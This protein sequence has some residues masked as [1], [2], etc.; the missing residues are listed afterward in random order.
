[1]HV[2]ERCGRSPMPLLL[3]AAVMCLAASVHATCDGFVRVEANNTVISDGN[4]MYPQDLDC[5]WL[6]VAPAGKV[7]SLT[8]SSMDLEPSCSCCDYLATWDGSN[9]NAFLNPAKVCTMSATPIVSQSRSMWVQF[10]TSSYGSFTGFTA[11]VTFVNRASEF[12]MCV[13]LSQCVCV[14]RVKFV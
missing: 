11:T 6:L 4:G 2:R 12:G 7:V 5:V 10:H 14:L 8:L 9:P 13:C 1:M 3:V